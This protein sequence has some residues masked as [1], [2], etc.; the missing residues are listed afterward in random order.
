VSSHRRITPQ[1]SLASNHGAIGITI[2]CQYNMWTF[3][4][5]S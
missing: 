2:G 1:W 5:Y 4:S 3:N